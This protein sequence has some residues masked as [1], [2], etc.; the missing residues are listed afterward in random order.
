[1]K[2]INLD[3]IAPREYN[4][5]I[6]QKLSSQLR[7]CGKNQQITAV[8]SCINGEGKST[9]A[10]YLSMFLAKAGK[11][12]IFIDAD[13]NKSVLA[14]RYKAEYN[15]GLSQYL[16]ELS[17]F[18]ETVCQTSI[19]SLDVIF[20]GPAMPNSTE[21]LDSEKF[22]STLESLRQRYDSI[23]VDTSSI[24]DNVDGIVA[25]KLCDG[26]IL[27]I[28][29]GAVSRK[30]IHKTTIRAEEAGIK[31]MGVVLNKN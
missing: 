13:I 19:E 1:M 4:N 8:T 20:S 10:L 18:D 24:A 16:S 29:A 11:K 26:A 9:V 6:Y 15:N 17:N 23:I 30:L 5:E 7:Y 28:E 21:L 2:K 3:Q 22:T 27:I 25:A 31:F 14:D 12:V